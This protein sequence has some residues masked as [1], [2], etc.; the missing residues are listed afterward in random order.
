MQ[1]SG[2]SYAQYTL[3]RSVERHLSL[4]LG[5]KTKYN[6]ATIMYAEG[7]VDY[8]ILEIANGK[9]QYRFN[10]GSGEGLVTL[11]DKFVND[12]DWHEVKLERHGNSA[13]IAVDGKWRA[14]PGLNDI[15]NLEQV[16]SILEQVCNKMVRL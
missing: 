9:L 3:K 16:I 6:V 10:F 8:S 4:S 11:N 1:F 5:F 13:E 7:L 2:R 14:A 12:G 15:L